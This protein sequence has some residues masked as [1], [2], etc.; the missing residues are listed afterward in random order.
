LTESEQCITEKDVL[1][2]QP[3]INK[4][5]LSK[6]ILLYDAD[7]DSVENFDINI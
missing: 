7:D 3:H 4:R 2:F 6:E 1:F 5:V